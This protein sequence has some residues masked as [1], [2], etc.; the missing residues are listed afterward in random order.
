MSVCVYGYVCVCIL[1]VSFLPHSD[2]FAAQPNDKGEQVSPEPFTILGNPNYTNFTM[3]TLQIVRYFL[4][5]QF[6]YLKVDDLL[7]FMFLNRN[8]TIEF[9]KCIRDFPK[10]EAYFP[11]YL[12]CVWELKQ[13]CLKKEIVVRCFARFWCLKNQ[14]V[15]RCFTRFWCLKNQIVVRCFTRFWCLKSQ[16]VVRCFACFGVLRRRL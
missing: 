11:R 6:E 14:I 4:T 15:V 2:K 1:H 3:E 13:L 12:G 16:I 8:N 7:N 9:Y 10:N 5:C